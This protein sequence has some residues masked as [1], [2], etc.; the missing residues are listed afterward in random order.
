VD[1]NFSDLDLGGAVDSGG[2][3]LTQA[4]ELGVRLA[5]GHGPLVL[6]GALPLF[7]AVKA[8]DY[9]RRRREERVWIGAEAAVA[10]VGR[11]A[12]PRGK[13][14]HEL[15]PA[16]PAVTF[17]RVAKPCRSIRSTRKLWWTP[18]GEYEE[19]QV[20]AVAKTN[21][22]KNAT[23]F[24]ATCWNVLRHRK[25]SAVVIDVKGDLL[26]KLAPRI[27]AGQWVFTFLE[28]HE[29]SSAINL[30][31]TPKMAASTAAALYPVKH[32]KVPAFNMGARD[33]FEAL[34]EALGYSESNL[35]ELFSCL[36]DRERMDELAETNERLRGALTGEN[37]K[38]VSDVINSARLPLAA[39]ARPEVARVFAPAP[40]ASQPHFLRKETVWI[41]IPQDA[42]DVAIL[43]GAIVHN[44]YN[45]AAKSR[46]GTYFLVDEAGSTI[47]IE[48]LDK[49]L[50]VGRGLGA[51]FFLILQDISQLQSK[52]GEAKTRSVLGNAGVQFW[53]KS[54]D[55]ETARYASELSGVVR[56]QFRA[57][58]HHGGERAWKQFWS[59]T[60]APYQLEDRGRAGIMPEHVHGLPKGWWYVYSGEP[61]D[62]ELCV[63]APMFEWEEKVLPSQAEGARMLAVPK[64]RPE[65]DLAQPAADF[66]PPE[67]PS[68]DAPPPDEVDT[69]SNA[70]PDR[71]RNGR[72][73][74]GCG[75]P[76]SAAVRFCGDCGCRL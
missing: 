66:G 11:L 75:R 65:T 15:N 34:A 47:T 7:A 49:Y 12:L 22:G 71:A 68:P 44:L 33:L 70:E 40:G 41:C 28:E 45:R 61:T 18:C 74:P 53:G 3:L 30:I 52:I 19:P 59:A 2:N 60:G 8:S 32:V 1:W 24:D 16:L 50:Q 13:R 9:R 54:G 73:C 56:V 55:T 20:V 5:E 58:E 37:R 48:N 57:Y 35:V 21:S 42:E 27:P 31:E 64:R 39:L 10:N 63:P 25:E 69:P 29:A 23:L 14:A 62:I 46:R 4:S 51:Y 38:F 6:A 36:G 72:P 43:A 67:E 76:V 17:R 26:H